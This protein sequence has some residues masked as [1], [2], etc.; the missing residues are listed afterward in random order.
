MAARTLRMTRREVSALFPGDPRTRYDDAML[1]WS[2]A[3]HASY[4]AF[5]AEVLPGWLFGPLGVVLF[6]RYFNRWHEALHSD[7]RGASRWHPARA[8]LVVVS[9]VYLGRAQLEELHVMHH[10]EEGSEADPDRDMMECGPLRSA[11]LC[12]VQPEL[13]AWWYL[14]RRGLDPRLAVEMFTHAATWSALMWLGGLRGFVAYNLVVRVGN[15]LAWLVFA[16]LVHQPWLY[17]H[18]EPPEFPRPL[19]WL[20]IA[21][22][23]RE[24]Y[25]GVRFHFL[26]HLFTAVPDRRLPALARRL[27]PPAAESAPEGA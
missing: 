15:A 4:F 14:R 10:R 16:W 23:G 25:L 17:G 18:V 24:N 26:H 13:M 5:V 1:G 22:V 27:H 21:L 6:L 12:L 2:L 20:W 11:L 19:R 8:L 9:P 3:F 7:Q